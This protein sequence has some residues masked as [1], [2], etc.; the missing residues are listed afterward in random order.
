MFIDKAQAVVAGGQLREEEDHLLPLPVDAGEE[1]EGA[2]EFP[3][4]PAHGLLPLLFAPGKPAADHGVLVP[5]RPFRPVR[6]LLPQKTGEFIQGGTDLP[7]R[8]LLFARRRQTGIL[9]L[10]KG[11]ADLVAPPADQTGRQGP[12]SLQVLRLRLTARL[13]EAVAHLSQLPEQALLNGLVLSAGGKGLPEGV[14]QQTDEAELLVE[15]RILHLLDADRIDGEGFPAVRAP[16]CAVCRAAA[17]A[18]VVTFLSCPEKP[19]GQDVRDPVDIAVFFIQ[20]VIGGK[21]PGDVRILQ[22]LDRQ[23]LIDGDP[24]LFM[25][26][27]RAGQVLPA[28]GGHKVPAL[29]LR[30][31]RIEVLAPDPQ[32]GHDRAMQTGAGGIF[33]KGLEILLD[34][35]P[36]QPVQGHDVEIPHGF[37]VLGRIARGHD[38]KAVRDP[39]GAEGLVLEKL[40]HGRRQR[41]GDAV[42]LIQ[43]KDAL[44]HARGLDLVIHGRDDLAHRILGDGVLPSPVDLP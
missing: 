26:L 44:L 14:C 8:A 37:I 31:D 39:V 17:P 3:V 6:R 18:S 13:L 15:R 40:Q 23:R 43:K 5:G 12:E 29:H 4:R 7:L 9:P 24:L 20:V 27:D 2:A 38:D 22:E 1:A 16:V 36:A 28:A 42:D 11:A 21:A 41:L 33:L 19:S 35:D 30:A 34:V 32:I 25:D 10:L